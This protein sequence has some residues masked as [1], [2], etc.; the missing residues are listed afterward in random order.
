MKRINF[1]KPIT[2][3]RGE[4]LKDEKGKKL[5]VGDM[6]LNLLGQNIKLKENRESFW[7]VELG[8]IIANGKPGVTEL[9]DDKWEFLKRIVNENRYTQIGEVAP[10]EYFLPFVLGQMMNLFE[11]EKPKK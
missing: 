9:Q 5:T 3:I 2:D 10:K 11:D 7:V 4:Q 1:N 6:M 8:I